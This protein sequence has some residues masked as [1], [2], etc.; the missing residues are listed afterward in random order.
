MY[1]PG[2]VGKPFGTGSFARVKKPSMQRNWWRDSI[3]PLQYRRNQTELDLGTAPIQKGHVQQIIL[4]LVR[5]GA[6]GFWTLQ[7]HYNIYIHRSNI[8]ASNQILMYVKGILAAPPKATP[9]SNKGSRRPYFLEGVALGGGY[10][11]FSW[12][13]ECLKI[14]VSPVGSKSP[15]QMI[16]LFSRFTQWGFRQT[17]MYWV[18]P[19]HRIP[20]TTRMTLHF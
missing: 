12:V 16:H 13:W 6:R 7:I 20:V 14:S 1:N 18:W 17:H 19:P 5:I 3:H 9:P 4:I 8:I 2:Q 10:L 15:A 11:R